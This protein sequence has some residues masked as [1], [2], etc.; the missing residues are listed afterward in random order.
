VENNF[1][2]EVQL[3][4]DGALL[5]KATDWWPQHLDL[6]LSYSHLSNGI[7]GAL[8]RSWN[9]VNGGLYIGDPDQDSLSGSL[10]GWLPFNVE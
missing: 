8:S 3:F 6:S 7:D 2:P 1:E 10:I 5:A 4:A 9:H